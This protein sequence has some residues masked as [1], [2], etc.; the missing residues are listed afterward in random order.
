M[1]AALSAK[2]REPRVHPT[3]EEASEAIEI[4]DDEEEDEPIVEPIP[5]QVGNRPGAADPKFKRQL[6]VVESNTKDH[7]GEY[8]A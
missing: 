1:H 3:E 6:A 8:Y 5:F 2:C 4:N 7:D